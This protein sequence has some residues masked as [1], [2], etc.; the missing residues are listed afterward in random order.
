MHTPI[1]TAHNIDDVFQFD[2]SCLLYIKNTAQ[3]MHA[4][5]LY[6]LYWI[7]KKEIP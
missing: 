7:T 6:G 3:D 1:H 5:N 2:I 4:K